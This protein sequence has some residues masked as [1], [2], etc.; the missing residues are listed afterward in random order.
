MRGRVTGGRASSL[1]H[2]GVPLANC[3]V[4]H[5]RGLTFQLRAVENAHGRE[6]DPEEVEACGGVFEFW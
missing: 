1:A 4:L 5:F 3:L 2:L 6:R